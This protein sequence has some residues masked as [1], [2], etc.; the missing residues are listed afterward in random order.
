MKKQELIEA[1]LADKESKFETKAEATRAVVSVLDAM[2][3]GIKKDG[4]LQ[5]IGFGTFK[6]KV[7]AARKGRNPLTGEDIKIKASK[8]VAFKTG[9]KLKEAIA[10]TKAK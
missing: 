6:V 3:K 4:E 2:Q 8:R 10:R 7:R 1:V 9:T 5:L